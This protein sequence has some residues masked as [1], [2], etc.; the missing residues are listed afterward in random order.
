MKMHELK[1][2]PEYFD[3][4]LKGKKTFEIRKNDRNFKEGDLLLLREFDPVSAQYTEQ[5]VMKQICYITSF[6]QRKG[7]VVLG[8]C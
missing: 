4:V 5:E 1:I 6:A 7:Y 3:A 2:Q 8:I